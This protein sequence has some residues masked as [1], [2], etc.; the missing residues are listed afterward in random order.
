MPGFVLSTLYVLTHLI[1]TAIFEDVTINVSILRTRKYSP[2][3][4]RTWSKFALS[5][6]GGVGD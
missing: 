5:A 1:I 2:E 3:R 4:F 6:S